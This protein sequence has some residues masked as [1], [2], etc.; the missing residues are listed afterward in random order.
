MAAG[1]VSRYAAITS[2]QIF[3]GP[4][5]SST[6][7]Q[8]SSPHRP[9]VA[10]L[11]VG[12]VIFLSS[13]SESQAVPSFARQLNMQCI[14]CHTE[15]PVL[16][17]FGRLF[18]LN[19]Y[20]LSAGDSALPVA[21]M[22]QPSF[23]QTQASQP[24]DA[25]PGFKPNRNPALTQASIFYAGRLFGPYAANLFGPEGAAIANKFGIFSQTTYSGIDKKWAWDNT[26]LRFADSGKI[27]ARDVVYGVYLN[28]NPTMQDPWNS[29]PAWGFPFTSSDLA[30]TPAASPLIAGGLAQQ[31]AGLGAYLMVSST[32]YLELGGYHTLGAQFQ[33]S[34]GVDPTDET[35]VTG[36][37]PY[38]RL[39]AQKTVAGGTWEFGTF[40]LAA[41]TYPGRDPSAGKDAIVDFGVD[42]QYQFS[43]ERSD[44]TIMGSVI[45]E[46]SRWQASQALG[47]TS[48][49]VDRLYNEQVTVDYLYDKTF[50]AAVQVFNLDGSADPLLYPGSATGSPNSSGMVYQLNFL[51]LNKGG[52]PA[53]WPRSNVKFSVQYVRYNRFDGGKTN[54]DGAGRNASDNNTLYFEAWIVF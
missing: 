5:N 37:A 14:A 22:L 28:N 10:A 53:F 38:W 4:K 51:P 33:K 24:D 46:R 18:K 6:F 8:T 35:Q 42:S 40:G 48:K 17:D 32:V 50:G 54:F 13:S 1:R 34:L 2:M 27:G 21:L 52:G 3:P 49:G 41:R 12:T 29:T 31:V 11:L 26:E 47:A 7:S 20:T 44:V 15:F 43:T 9:L 36:L 25:A 16:N 39:A 23:T 30:P 19:G 45:Y